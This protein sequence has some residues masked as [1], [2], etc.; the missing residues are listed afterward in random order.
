M[1][2]HLIL[3]S[4]LATLLCVWHA[5]SEIQIGRAR[6]CAVLAH[7]HLPAST[8]ARADVAFEELGQALR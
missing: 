2:K 5:Q 6:R 8:P 1:K 4:T 7:L 3:L